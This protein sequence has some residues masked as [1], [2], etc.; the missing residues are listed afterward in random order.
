MPTK[1]PM[2]HGPC[3]LRRAWEGPRGRQQ[4][5]EEE[6]GARAVG[7]PPQFHLPRCASVGGL[8]GRRRGVG[9]HGVGTPQ[10]M[11]LTAGLVKALTLA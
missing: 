7:L 3:L 5:E 8:R 11:S 2:E 9:A 4:V 1:G 10:A 6:L